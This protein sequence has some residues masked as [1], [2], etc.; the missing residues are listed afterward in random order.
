MEILDVLTRLVVAAALT[1]VIGLDR[2]LRAKAAG[3][4]TNI[5][6]GTATAAFALIGAELINGPPSDPGRVA[7]QVVSGIGF[8]GGGA[9]FAAGGKPSGLTTAAALWGSAAIGLAAGVAAYDVAVALV[10]VLFVA[11]WPLDLVT[12]RLLQARGRHDVQVQLVVESLDVL[13]RIRATL[14]GDLVRVI[15]MQ[16]SEL[17]GQPMV[18]LRLSGSQREVTKVLTDFRYL[19]GVSAIASGAVARLGE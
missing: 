1:A 12:H 2:E 4:R 5:V 17:G 6:V 11:L 18:E 7:A 16:L 19:E 15:E 8:L 9:I 13:D 10:F 14:V 3:L